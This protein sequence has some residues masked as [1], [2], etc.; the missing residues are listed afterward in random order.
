[1]DLAPELAP[2]EMPTRVEEIEVL[3]INPLQS[4]ADVIDALRSDELI[5]TPVPKERALEAVVVAA[6]RPRTEL[7]KPQ[8]PRA[9]K[10]RP[11]TRPHLPARTSTESAPPPYASAQAELPAE[12]HAELQAP[13]RPSSKPGERPVVRPFS[14]AIQT[15]AVAPPRRGVAAKMPASLP[16]VP[17]APEV[18][19][20]V[21]SVLEAQAE[22]APLSVSVP[23]SVPVPPPAQRYRRASDVRSVSVMR[24][25]EPVRWD[26][27]ALLT[28]L[29]LGVF[30]VAVFGVEAL[31]KTESASVV[32]LRTFTLVLVGVIAAAF[33]SGAKK[34]LHPETR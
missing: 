31:E 27:L 15:F 21:L 19:G 29:A 1:L 18:Y 26:R 23:V 22:R 33:W 13:P 14:A 6:P 9:P 20:E 16:P 30:V 4:F 2:D 34:V 8:P 7:P 3:P 11:N 25:K 5:E 24:P 17:V 32:W 12:L 28:V 10:A